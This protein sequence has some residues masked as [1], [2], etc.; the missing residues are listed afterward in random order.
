MLT[1]WAYSLFAV[2][3]VSLISFVGI[4]TISLKLEALKKV[5]MLFSSYRCLTNAA[6]ARSIFLASRCTEYRGRERFRST[7]AR[8]PA[9]CGSTLSGQERG[10]I[11]QRRHCGKGR[12]F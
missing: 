5:V 10:P 3:G 9:S 8:R 2:F 11:R 6:V 12:I 4:F 1:T 7:P